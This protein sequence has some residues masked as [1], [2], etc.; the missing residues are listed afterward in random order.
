MTCVD[1]TKMQRQSG[2]RLYRPPR[3]QKGPCI[4]EISLGEDFRTCVLTAHDGTAC[5]QNHLGTG[6]SGLGLAENA[7]VWECR[8]PAPVS[9]FCDT[10][11]S[12]L[13]PRSA[14]SRLYCQAA[15]R[16]CTVLDVGAGLHKLLA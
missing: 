2:M 16:L 14:S 8:R 3:R 10:V 9:R 1:G 13:S 15:V 4:I 5:S 11:H 12:R 6:V 7:P